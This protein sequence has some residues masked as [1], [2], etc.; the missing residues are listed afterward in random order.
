[1]FRR[2]GG[3][4]RYG[5]VRR[6]T[7]FTLVEVIVVLVILAIL[8]AIAI[9]ALTGYIDKAQE[10]KYIA[11]AR[12]AFVAT[13][14]VVSDMYIEESTIEE[15]LTAHG[16]PDFLEMGYHPSNAF[17]AGGKRA[18]PIQQFGEY[19]YDWSYFYKKITALMS[20][21]LPPS[22]PGGWSMTLIGPNTTGTTIFNADGF[23][24]IFIPDDSN[25]RIIVTY[26]IKEYSFANTGQFYAYLQTRSAFGYDPNEGYHLYDTVTS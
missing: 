16:Y 7:G 3:A 25:R 8:A 26:K 13:R 20:V 10:K 22:G 11:D 6:R 9:P 24:Y 2:A 19:T 4:A 12:N 5:G 1:M 15:L 23:F 18:Y 17:L 21:P 14:A